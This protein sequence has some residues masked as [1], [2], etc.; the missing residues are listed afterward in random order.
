MNP[1]RIATQT[2]G[3]EIKVIVILILMTL[4][5]TSVVAAYTKGGTHTETRLNLEFAQALN[6]G[7]TAAREKDREFFLTQRKADHDA[8]LREDKLLQTLSALAGD[9]GRLRDT[10]TAIRR[11]L[12]DLTSEAVRRYADTASVVVGECQERYSA[13]AEAA[14]RR[15][16]DRDKL[17]QSWPK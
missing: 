9:S 2:L 17:D 10:V 1:I 15:D 4:W 11:D 5:M 14:D 12:P 3:T 7:I 16:I 6:R 8:Q 13:V